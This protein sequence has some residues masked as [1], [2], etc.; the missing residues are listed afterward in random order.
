MKGDRA[1]LT[2]KVGSLP[3]EFLQVVEE[4]LKAALD[5]D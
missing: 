4:G 5:L 2:K 1:K 3:P